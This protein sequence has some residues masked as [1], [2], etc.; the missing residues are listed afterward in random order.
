[1]RKFID[2]FKLLCLKCF[3]FGYDCNLVLEFVIKVR[4]YLSCLEMKDRGDN[5]VICVWK[6]EFFILVSGFYF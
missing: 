3:F 4:L 2:K 6:F 1:M 5:R